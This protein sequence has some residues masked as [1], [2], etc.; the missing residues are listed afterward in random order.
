MYDGSKYLQS[1]TTYSDNMN[2][3]VSEKDD[4]NISASYTYDETG[5]VTSVTDGSNVTTSYQNDAM[6]YLKLAQTSVSN[7]S[8]NKTNI[9]LAFNYNNDLLT[10]VTADDVVY[11]YTY[12]NWSQTKAVSVDNQ[13]LVEYNYGVNE[14]RSRVTYI[15]SQINSSSNY[16]LNYIYDLHG[17]IVQV[18]KTVEI[19]GNV[20]E[21]SYYYHYDNLGTLL[22]IDDSNTGRIVRYNADGGVTIEET[23]TN[24]VIYKSYY[25]EDGELVEEIDGVTYTAKSYSA[26]DID[27]E[28]TGVEIGYNATTGNTTELEAVVSSNNKNFG[29]QT[30]TDWFGRTKTTTVMTKDPTD[31][32]IEYPAKVRSNRTFVSYDSNKTT[33]LVKN[34]T[35]QISGVSGSRTANFVYAYDANG[36]IVSRKTTGTLSALVELNT[37]VY[38]EAGQLVRE[39][40][41]KNNN[42]IIQKTWTYE[43]DANG[44]ITK[45]K[46]YNYTVAGTEPTTLISTDTFTYATG[47]WEDRLVSYNGQS[48]V[49]DNIGNPT[50]YLGATLTWHG[51]ELLGYSKGENSYYYSYDVDGMRYQKVVNKNGVETARYNYVYADGQLILLS[52]TTGGTTQNAKFIYS[53]AGEVLGFIVDGVS[54]YLYV[55]NLQ[56]DIVAIVNETGVPVVRYIYDAWGNVTITTDSG[57]ENLINLSPFAYRGYCYDNDIKMY[58]LQSRYY[59]PQICRFINADSSE[60]LG[61]TETVLSYNLFA[62]CENDPV[63]YDDETGCALN[64]ASGYSYGYNYSANYRPLYEKSHYRIFCTINNISVYADYNNGVIQVWNKQS[65]IGNLFKGSTKTFAYV[66]YTSA[67]KIN[68]NALA[69]RTING[70]AYEL[71]AHYV[72]YKKNIVRGKSEVTDC[73]GT[74]NAKIGYDYNA[75]IFEEDKSKLNSVEKLVKQGKLN[76]ALAKLSPTLSK[77]GWQKVRSK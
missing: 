33:N 11:T 29:V 24:D 7:L 47:T 45:R 69:K 34:Y 73:G 41:N 71:I 62:Y 60:Y 9:S 18:V 57:Y 12:D 13:K 30:L 68:P 40:K 8:D 26:D 70:I 55:K 5:A 36:K 15:E 49:Y 75:Y 50:T 4:N 28:E 59:D 1:V 38:D 31:T 58:Y 43:Y 54:Q 23:G 63:D 44:N 21:I 66:L 39:D 37:Y 67:R 25:N 61:A 56:G 42:E 19:D 35:N 52:Y 64:S 22:Y 65:N 74:G 77:L 76:S 16:T 46:T 32:E 48:I 17:N 53:S 27:T 14:Y 20:D 3:V 10:T 6:G 72:W 2:Y 51:R